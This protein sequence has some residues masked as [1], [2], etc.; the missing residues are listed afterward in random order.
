MK[1]WAKSEPNAALQ[2]YEEMRGSLKL[3][4]GLSNK[5]HN[6]IASDLIVGLGLSDPEQALALYERTP[7]NEMKEYTVR[8]L[9][10]SCTEGMIRSGDD[11]HLLRL[12]D[13]HSSQDRK[14]ILTASFQKFGEMRKFEEG[15]AF[16][17]QHNGDPGDQ[18][19][20]IGKMI[21][22]MP[23]QEGS[24]ESAM[25]WALLITPEAEAPKAVRR[26]AAIAA[27]ERV[28]TE[29]DVGEW[30]EAQTL[31]LVRD[32]GYFGLVEGNLDGYLPRANQAA[33]KIDDA[34]LQAAALQAIAEEIVRRE[35]SKNR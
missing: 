3:Y 12:I 6:A 20:Y 1:D 2:W 11:T 32:S 25:D 22:W 5:L 17:D 18:L 35:E 29:M 27:S 26:F 24:V 8:W 16:I 4:P 34:T 21:T 15:L 23:L 33:E 28:V 13:A 7:R 30:L 9:S 19:D 10:A 31:G 14:D